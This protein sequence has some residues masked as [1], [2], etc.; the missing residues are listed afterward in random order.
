MIVQRVKNSDWKVCVLGMRNVFVTDIDVFL[1]KIEDA[2]GSCCF[3]V[4]DAD[5]IAGWE[6][7]FYGAVN[8][9]AAFESD[10]QVSNS[11]PIETLLYVSCQDQ[12]V[13]GF[14]MVGVRRDIE[15]IAL[16]F[17]S[18]SM[19]EFAKILVGIEIFGSLDDSVM[20]V[21]DEKLEVLKVLYE[22]SD[23]AFETIE[24]NVF[25]ILTSL[26]VEKGALIPTFR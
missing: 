17:F 19:E 22:V 26:V 24:G 7:V 11:L 9:I 8:A 15:R 2:T 12:I 20:E 3:Q 21:T 14:R 25:E 5:K 6:H 4:F 1:E 23:S 10:L 13:K 16:V 18:K